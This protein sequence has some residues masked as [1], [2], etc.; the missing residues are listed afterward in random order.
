MTGAGAYSYS[1][2]GNVLENRGTLA[3]QAISGAS[4]QN[5]GTLNVNTGTLTLAQS[6]SGGAE[7]LSGTFNV[8]DG[9]KL[10][11]SS[12]T[13]Q[14]SPTAVFNLNNTGVVGLSNGT[15]NSGPTAFTIPRLEVS[16]GTVT[17]TGG[18]VVT[19]ALTGSGLTL[20]ATTLTSQGSATLTNT[21]ITNT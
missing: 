2:T 13:H 6:G 18:T 17:G 11:L 16:S 15:L 12:G 14:F 9:A 1:G 5:T 3:V 4:L 8:A 7:I 10:G 19:G 20:D 21:Q